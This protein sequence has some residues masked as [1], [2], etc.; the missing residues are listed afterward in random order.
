MVKRGGGRSR[1]PAC[2][3]NAEFFKVFIP[4]LNSQLLKIPPDFIKDF[5]RTIQ[6]KVI[7]K[8]IGGKIWHID[9][10]KT[11]DGVF[12]KNGWEKFVDDNGFKVGEFLLFSYDGCY[13]F[14]V[15][16]FDTNG[17]KRKSIA[18]DKIDTRVKIEE[19]TENEIEAKHKR[20]RVDEDDHSLSANERS[21]VSRGVKEVQNADS[22]PPENCADPVL[23]ERPYFVS[24]PIRARL[25]NLRI[26]RTLMSE[27]NIHLEPEMVLRTENGKE[28]A[29]S[30]YTLKD[31]RSHIGRGLSI[32]LKENNVGYKDC[33]KFTFQTE[34][35]S[36]TIDVQILRASGN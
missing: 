19:N 7:L 1:K 33:C 25:Y 28:W 24:P 26:P 31:G 10:E 21:E 34:R 4:H 20:A 27:H 23:P 32:F 16:I 14:V 11:R 9:V 6:E 12:L 5:S 22:E 17:C 18:A 30:A 13:S 29:V 3:G 15:K 35:L 2:D 36:N 8:G